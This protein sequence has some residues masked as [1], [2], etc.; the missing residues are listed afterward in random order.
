[1]FYGPYTGRYFEFDTQTDIEHIVAT[2]E[3]HDSGLCRAS[4]RK[5]REFANDPLNITLA[6]PKVNR[7]GIGGKCGL[8]AAEWMPEKNKCW[9]ANRVVTIKTIHL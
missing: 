7:C 5:R 1:M 9:F 4:M 6:S 3:G 8:D 2:S